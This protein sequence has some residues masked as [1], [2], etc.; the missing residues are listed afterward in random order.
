MHHFTTHQRPED[1]YAVS[2]EM[3][4]H[5]EAEHNLC[6][7]LLRKLSETKPTYL[8]M[9]G[10]EKGEVQFCMMRTELHL[11]LCGSAAFGPSAAEELWKRGIAVESVL[12]ENRLVGSFAERYA[13]LAG[14]Q[15]RI[16]MNQGVY[17]LRTL[18]E[19]PISPGH[20]RK[21]ASDDL[22]LVT[23]WNIQFQQDVG[24]PVSRD[25]IVEKAKRYVEDGTTSLWIDQGEIVSMVNAAR[26]TVNGVVV[27]Q[28]FTPAH[29][30]GHGYASSCVATFSRQLLERYQ[31]CALYTDMDNPTSNKIYQRMGYELVAESKV[32]EFD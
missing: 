26:P 1:L 13:E 32:I 22:D 11:I 12:G 2:I 17:E 19:V 30:R 5:K 28:V 8:F 20:L 9:S 14:K 10:K 7:G 18:K 24:M 25:Y 27:N 21:V 6:I 15:T 29:L 3:L 4:L 23:E 31:F 16:Q